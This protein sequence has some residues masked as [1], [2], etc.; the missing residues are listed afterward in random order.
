[1]PFLE[2]GILCG[3]KKG[4]CP[5]FANAPF[6]PNTQTANAVPLR[7]TIGAAV[8]RAAKDRKHASFTEII[9]INGLTQC[10]FT[11]AGSRGIRYHDANDTK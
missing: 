11:K 9:I 6:A 3:K 2:K 5:I 4:G 1:M 10:F 8:L 7:K